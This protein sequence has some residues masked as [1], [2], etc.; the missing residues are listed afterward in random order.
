M[1]H[2]QLQNMGNNAKHKQEG[3][4]Q[5]TL[6]KSHNKSHWKTTTSSANEN[7]LKEVHNLLYYTKIQNNISGMCWYLKI[8]SWLSNAYCM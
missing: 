4:N 1:H 7:E 2:T 3:N 5:A 6:K 8:S